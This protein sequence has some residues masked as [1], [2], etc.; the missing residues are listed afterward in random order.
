MSSVHYLKSVQKIPTSVEEAWA[1]FSNAKNL[2]HITPPFL[3]LK[4]TSALSDEEVFAGQSMTYKVKPILNIPLSW[5][6]EITEVERLK[7]FV[8]EQKKGPYKLW[9]HQHHFKEIEGGVEMTDLVVYELP[10]GLLG[11]IVHAITAKKKLRQIFTYRY[12]K[13]NELF[14]DWPG[15]ELNLVFDQA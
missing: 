6:T 5:T 11:N 10:F 15:S 2:L 14:G 4:V 12:Y 1:F 7:L 13:I 9:R 8:D 3:N